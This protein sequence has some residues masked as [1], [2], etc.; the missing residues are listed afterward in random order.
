MTY[1]Q[2]FSATVF[3][4][5]FFSSQ[6]HTTGT[7]APPPQCTYMCTGMHSILSLY[8]NLRIAHFKMARYEE[9]GKDL[10]F[11]HLSNLYYQAIPPPVRSQG[12]ENALQS[13]TCAR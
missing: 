13:D 1:M 12:F 6:L 7:T 11:W 4:Y 8:A 10:G 5:I 2:T 3:F 9:H